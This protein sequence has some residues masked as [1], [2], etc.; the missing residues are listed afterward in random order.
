[1]TGIPSCPCEARWE[2]P[3]DPSVTAKCRAMVREALTEWNLHDLVDDV[4]VVVTELLGNAIIHGAPPIHLAL[5]AGP[6]MLT[7]A[8]TD[9]GEGWPRVRAAGTELEHG[10]GLRIV[11]ALTD[12]W[13][14][15]HVPAGG[16]KTIWFTCVLRPAEPFEPCAPSGPSVPSER[17]AP[18]APSE[19]SG[20]ARP[21]P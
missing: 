12:L 4:V 16:G 6:G 18:S 11:T 13:G 19:L 7:G 1:M 21:P 17:S 8:V 2:L 9:G 15:Q 10:R 3:A 5:R 20:N 14:V